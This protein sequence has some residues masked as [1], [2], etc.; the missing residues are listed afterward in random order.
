MTLNDFNHAA[1]RTPLRP[2]DYPLWALDAIA[3]ALRETQHTPL[4][5]AF[6]TYAAEAR[7][8]GAPETHWADAFP[9]DNSRAPARTLPDITECE[10]VADKHLQAAAQALPALMPGYEI[11]PGQ[12]DMLNAVNAAIANQHHLV[13]EAGTGIGKSLACLIPAALWSTQNDLPIIISTNTK[14]L[15]SQLTDKDL[16][17]VRALL[18]TAFPDRVPLRTALL[19]GRSNYLCLRR[20]GHLLSHYY[21]LDPADLPHFARLVA[22]ALQTPDGDLET[23]A[24]D[25]EDASTIRTAAS[26]NGEECPGRAC[27][28]YTRCYL[29]RARQHA[30]QAHLIITNHALVF[31]D[32]QSGGSVLPPHHQLI[33]DEAHNLEDAATRHYAAEFSLYALHQTL[34]RLT[35]SKR[36]KAPD[37]LT[38]LETQ[39]PD[40]LAPAIREARYHIAELL[41]A[42]Q[43][44]NTHGLALLDKDE[45]RR[46]RVTP[47]GIR[48]LY[49][50]TGVKTAPLP[51][52][53]PEA[54]L[55][56]TLTHLTDSANNAKATLQHIAEQIEKQNEGAL[57]LHADQQLTLTAA[58]DQLAS[59]ART[60]TYI[61][62]GNDPTQVY[63][64]ERKTHS[65]K[66]TI[67]WN[68]V[69]LNIAGL[70]HDTLFK[71]KPTV[72][73]CSATLRVGSSFSHYL[74]RSGL[75]HLPERTQ[76]LT[77]PSPFNYHLQCR[78]YALKYL[79]EP[80]GSLPDSHPYIPALAQ[81]ILTAARHYQGRTLVLYTG[82]ALMHAV[83]I[84]TH[85]QL[86]ALG[87]N[88]LQQGLD[89]SR[90]QLTQTLRDHPN[91]ILYGTQSFWEGID[92]IGPALQCVIITR[93]P[94]TA[95]GDPLL[96]ARCEQID[97]A[98]GN[99]FIELTLPTATVKLKQGFGRLIRSKTDTGTIIIADPRILTKRYGTTLI[100]SLPAP[101]IPLDTPQQLQD[102]LTQDAPGN[103][104]T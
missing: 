20:Y 98:G 23:Y 82:Y 10:P 94:F 83:A 50:A 59:H 93:I 60:A 45:L 11:R 48:E 92:L 33:L 36:A 78:A 97:Q 101:I 91:T 88:L 80:T 74:R 34:R 7:L 104:N 102:R 39:Y 84:R 21:T 42:A 65:N 32:L 17:T 85:A 69:P 89:G 27:R 86:K 41:A 44:L 87:L 79:P 9:P 8:H 49:P 72:I 31:A 37:L 13:V 100:R 12:A 22:W 40:L 1:P 47:A 24:P 68:A 38:A 53:L 64:F 76:T 43:Q 57:N 25:A 14:N 28:Y 95:V 26:S 61:L 73:L 67:I 6:E 3:A 51:T 71:T 58:A 96:E 75:I 29:Q 62:A 54:T 4:A 81:T 5:R 66:D 2:Q 52:H 30:A 99:S 46:Y 70:L 63:W 16:P 55:A 90:D 77:A 18:A 35:P 103:P 19:K 15:Q 56:Q